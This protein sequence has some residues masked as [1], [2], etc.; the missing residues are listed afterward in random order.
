MTLQVTYRRLHV[1]QR[2]DYA[3]HE[4]VFVQ[5][6]YTAVFLDTRVLLRRL[7]LWNGGCWVYELVKV[8]PAAYDAN[9]DFPE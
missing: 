5:S 6:E 1:P 4:K 2:C 9:I 8:E 3:S 7:C